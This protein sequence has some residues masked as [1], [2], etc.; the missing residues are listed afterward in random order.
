MRLPIILVT[1]ALTLAVLFGARWLYQSQAFD[2]PLGE[3]VRAVPGVADVVV[4]QQGDA[5][6]V[7]VKAQ[8]VPDL[9]QFVK[10]LWRAID[11]VEP[12]QKVVLQLSDSRN[13]VL[14]DVYYSFNF[15]LQEAVATGRYSE[16]P[17]RLDQV[18]TPD[19]V[20]RARVYVDTDYVYVQLHQG[21]ASLYEIVPRE[22]PNPAAAGAVDVALHSI[23]VSPWGN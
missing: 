21:D 11:S 4:G 18:A 10:S 7:R 9:E 16:L 15:Y 23:T 1:L 5:V 14:Q 8:D 3:A 17:A 12:G 22:T 13:R 20:T 2:R 6:Q 19:R